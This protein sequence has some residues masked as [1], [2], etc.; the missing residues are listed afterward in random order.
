MSCKFG[1]FCLS[2]SFKRGQEDGH[3]LKCYSLKQ[4]LNL[5]RLITHNID[6]A[7]NVRRQEMNCS[8]LLAYR[9]ISTEE[10]SALGG[11]GCYYE[12]PRPGKDSSVV[13]RY[14]YCRRII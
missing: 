6:V 5:D 3:L 8:Q 10:R 2:V 14:E 13:M 9:D 7:E 12:G 1:L 11:S 4:P